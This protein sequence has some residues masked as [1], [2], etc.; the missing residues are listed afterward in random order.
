MVR[1]NLRNKKVGPAL[2]LIC[3]VKAWAYLNFKDARACVVSTKKKPARVPH[4]S[5]H[6]ARKHTREHTQRGAGCR[7]GHG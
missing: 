4:V 5:T 2:T 6:F 1:H 7:P 3:S